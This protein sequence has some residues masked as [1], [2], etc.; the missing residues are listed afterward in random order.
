M[1]AQGPGGRLPQAP[2]GT[3]MSA[4]GPGGGGGPGTASHGSRA[5]LDWSAELAQVLVTLQRPLVPH[6]PPQVGWVA[7]ATVRLQ[8]LWPLIKGCVQ[9]VA[10]S[11]GALALHDILLHGQVHEEQQRQGKAATSTPEGAVP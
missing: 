11:R 9:G 2:V 3:S 5:T 6:G 10:V 1:S 4:Q 8:M 7:A